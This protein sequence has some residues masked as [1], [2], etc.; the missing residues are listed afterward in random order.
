VSKK[1]ANRKFLSCS[2]SFGLFLSTTD[3]FQTPGKRLLSLKQTILKV[4]ISKF[5]FLRIPEMFYQ[6]PPDR[7]NT[8]SF[9]IS[10]FAMLIVFS[11]GSSR[12]YLAYRKLQATNEYL[13]D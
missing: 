8:I 4:Q 9:E 3:F 2:H 5:Q 6:Q 7:K 13:L 10:F 12:E 11:I 1:Y